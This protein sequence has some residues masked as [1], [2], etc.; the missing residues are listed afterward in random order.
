MNGKMVGKYYDI[1]RYPVNTEES[2]KLL[3]SNNAYTFIVDIRSNKS[4]IKKAVENVFDVKVISV[5]TMIRKGK[6]KVFRGRIGRRV[7]T[8]RAIVRLASGNKI[9]LGMGV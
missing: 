6:Q 1:I 8:K 2:N 3:T 9:E 4:D 7:N 5:N